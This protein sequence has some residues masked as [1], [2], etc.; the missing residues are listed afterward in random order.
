MN[1]ETGCF[2]NLV[3]SYWSESLTRV[4]K[5]DTDRISLP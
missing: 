1:R 2:I 4:V 3:R 5:Y